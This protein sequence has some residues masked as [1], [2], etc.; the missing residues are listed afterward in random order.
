MSTEEKLELLLSGLQRIALGT[1]DELTSN[2]CVT[3]ML[4]VGEVD[5]IEEIFFLARADNDPTLS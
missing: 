3:M 1:T 4:E 2:Y 5:R